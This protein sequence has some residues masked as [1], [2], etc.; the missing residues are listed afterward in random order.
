MD[1]PLELDYAAPAEKAEDAKTLAPVE[2]GHEI[3]T[4]GVK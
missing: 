3:T 1:V 4:K 2:Q